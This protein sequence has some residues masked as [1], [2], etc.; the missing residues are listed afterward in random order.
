M[1]ALVS[2][3]V[4][5]SIDALTERE[6]FS[7]FGGLRATAA[8][9]LQGE[10]LQAGSG[11]EARRAD[12]GVRQTRSEPTFWCDKSVTNGQNWLKLSESQEE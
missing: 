8:D 4:G 12:Y 2:D 5:R 6:S 3:Q 1:G 7:A 10:Q 9:G 11:N